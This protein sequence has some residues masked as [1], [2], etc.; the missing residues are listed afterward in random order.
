[1][2][3]PILPLIPQAAAGLP[4]GAPDTLLGAAALAAAVVFIGLLG[5]LAAAPAAPVEPRARPDILGQLGRRA[6][7]ICALVF[8]LKAALAGGLAWQSWMAQ[9]LH[10]ASGLAAVAIAFGSAAIACGGRAIRG[11]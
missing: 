2:L 8:G 10:G 11:R 5:F 1:M 7:L 4:A 9:G 3:S 6:A